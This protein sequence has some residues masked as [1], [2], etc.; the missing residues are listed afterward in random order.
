MTRICLNC[1]KTLNAAAE[2]EGYQTAPHP[3][4]WVICLYCGHLMVF[5]SNLKL[6][7]PNQEELIEMAGDPDI[8][9]MMRFRDTYLKWKEKH[10]P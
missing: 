5:T 8:V 1:S 6:R 9:G 10:N 7:D 4:D 3:Y 2:L